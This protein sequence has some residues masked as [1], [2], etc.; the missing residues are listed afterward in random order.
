MR[1]HRTKLA[2][3]F[4]IAGLVAGGVLIASNMGFKLFHPLQEAVVGTSTAGGNMISLPWV[5]PNAD[6]TDPFTAGDLLAD[7]NGG[8]CVGTPAAFVQTFNQDTN[9]M[10]THYNGCSG[11]DFVLEAG[12]AYLVV[13]REGTTYRITGTH[14]PSASVTFTAGGA[15]GTNT[16]AP[17][18]HSVANDAESLLAE[19]PNA[20]AVGRYDPANDSIVRY[21][22]VVPFT[23]NF[24]IVPGEGY[25]VS[26]SADTTYVPA[27]Y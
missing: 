11:T 15:D 12:V 2:A 22:G 9:T 25:F 8:A 1:R 16:Y 23:T 6:P 13:M 14:D 27:H 5:L 19:I 17:P 20:T 24:P 3:A 21:T 26:V 18:Y 4:L 7:I 10:T